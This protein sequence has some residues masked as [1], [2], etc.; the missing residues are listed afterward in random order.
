MQSIEDL[1]LSYR[2]RQQDDQ[3]GKLAFLEERKF[4][5]A[6][7]PKLW[8]DLREILKESVTAFNVGSGSTEVFLE[9]EPQGLT[10]KLLDGNYIKIE[11]HPEASRVL[12]TGHSMT[13]DSFIEIAVWNRDVVFR[14]V[15]PALSV[16][17][18][19][20]PKEVAVWVIRQLLR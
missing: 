2:G 20:S 5:K 17:A 18:T 10:L 16:W 14:R 19:V 12:F 15:Q 9:E 13:R 3:L 11:Y 7:S 4:I 6:R 1:V 8:S